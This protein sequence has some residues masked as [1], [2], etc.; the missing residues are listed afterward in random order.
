MRSPQVPFGGERMAA[1]PGASRSLVAF[2]LAWA[3]AALPAQAEETW[4]VARGPSH[5]PEPH[6]F[7]PAEVRK[8]PRDFLD[9]A[10]VCVLY[11]G[12]TYLVEPDGNLETITH[13][14]T[15]L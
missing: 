1:V 13:E 10:A 14:I 15:R 5:E 4:P 8:A 6:V 12:T 2:F 7:D 3:L 9:D 11:A